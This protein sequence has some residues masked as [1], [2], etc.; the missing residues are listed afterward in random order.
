MPGD[1]RA[2]PIRV[3]EVFHS[4]QGESTHTGRRCVFVRLGGCDLRCVWCDTKESWTGGAMTTIGAVLDE[5]ARHDC[6]LVEV[7]GGEPLL[8]PAA[9]PLLAALCDAG[10]EVLLETGG[11]RDVSVVDPRV[12]RIVDMK[13]PGSGE[14]A[15]NYL[16]NLGALRAGDELKFVVAGRDDYEWSRALLRRHALAPGVTV[17][18][19]PVHGVLA[20]G[21][22]GRWVVEDHLGPEVRVQVQLHKLL[23][24]P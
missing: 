20:P 19:S 16:P 10:Y 23:E 7:T 22:L 24:M 2:R 1:V 6:R 21:P 9:L 18:F 8:Q 14:V 17:L 3:L 12:R 11:H 13:P 4:I 15:S 5:V